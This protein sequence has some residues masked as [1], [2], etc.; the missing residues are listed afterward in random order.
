MANTRQTETKNYIKRALIHLL[1]RKTFEEISV[2]A[3]CR[4]AGINRGTFYL[5]YLDKYDMMD[6]LKNE[7]ISELFNI[8]TEDMTE[9]SPE[10]IKASLDYIYSDHEFFMVLA[11]STYVNLPQSIRHFVSA[12]IDLIPNVNSILG[13]VYGIPEK[14]ARLIYISSL[15]AIISNWISE[16][17]HESPQ[18]ITDIIVKI[19]PKRTE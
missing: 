3:I 9:L 2:T 18:E 14:Y 19:I 6:K 16:D 8:I 13:Q 17:M 12:V 11:D 10:L 1:K 4:E 5:H 7:T 15:E